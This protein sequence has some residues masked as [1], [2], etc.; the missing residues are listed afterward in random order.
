MGKTVGHYAPWFLVALVGAFIGLTLAPDA[1]SFLSWQV[2]IVL[3]AFAL[4]SGVSILLHNRQL[5]E[6]CIA[7]LPLDAATVADRYS[8]R[9]RTAHLFERKLIAIGYLATVL[10]SSFLSTHPVGRYAWALAQV[11]LIYLVLVY[12][13]HQRLQPWCPYCKNGGEE[14]NAPTPPRPI[15]ART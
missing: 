8:L 12:V 6:R 2:L 13:T 4:F 7:A 10:A 9:F 1:F 14:Q 11:S 5:C 3:L 15:P